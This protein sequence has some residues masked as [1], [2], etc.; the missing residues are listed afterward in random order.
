MG[1][2][3]TDLPSCHLTFSATVFVC[4]LFYF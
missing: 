1:L 2:W 4:L 3:R